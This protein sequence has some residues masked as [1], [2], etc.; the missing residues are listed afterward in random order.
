MPRKTPYA[1]LPLIL[2]IL[3]FL[4]GCGSPRE[5]K[6]G[7]SLGADYLKGA[8]MAAKEINFQ[9]GIGGRRL[10]LQIDYTMGNIAPVLAIQ[11]AAR[12]AEA[13]DILAVVGHDS[14]AASL[15]AAPVY[16]K[17]GV[18]QVTPMSTSSQLS[19][20]GRW[21]FQVCID[22]AQQGRTLADYAFDVLEKRKTFIFRVSDSYG[23]GLAKHFRERFI[24]R[25]GAVVYQAI[26]DQEEL[27]L[28]PFLEL[29]PRYSPDLIL[30]A[31]R[32]EALVELRRGLGKH[33]INIPVLGGE[34]I[35]NAPAI[36]QHRQLLEGL[37]MTRIFPPESGGEWAAAFTEN[38]HKRF[39]IAP[40][41]RAALSYDAVYLLKEAIEKGG[42]DR[43]G[44]RR[45]ILEASS[46][47]KPFI[48]V[49]GTLAIDGNGNTL[50]PIHIGVVR[51]GRVVPA[52]EA[53]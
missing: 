32:I 22:D 25:G 14:S 11:S 12:F 31:G 17:A 35:H 48:G 19:Q 30:F 13:R 26:Y 29:L 4:G 1:S 47:H 51:S 6:I 10:V 46:P 45:A 36:A 38:Y 40:D 34:A 3:L 16:N 53:Q 24:E 28:G 9:G 52:P 50:R 33:N 39:G 42:A 27:N 43:E 7:V 41:A 2:M 8:V 18:V 44:I 49:A 21:T 23:H 5:I 20:A 37:M 15:A